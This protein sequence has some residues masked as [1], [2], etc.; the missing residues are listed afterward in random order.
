MHCCLLP[1][2]CPQGSLKQ[3]LSLR[4]YSAWITPASGVLLVGGGSY[5]LLQRLLPYLQG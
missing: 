2:S 4:Q 3:L 5:V 1:P